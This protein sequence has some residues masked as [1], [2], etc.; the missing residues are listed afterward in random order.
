MICLYNHH[1]TKSALIY[2]ALGI[3]FAVFSSKIKSISADYE[4]VCFSDECSIEIEIEEDMEGPVY[5][6]Y[7]LD[8]F[9][10]NHFDYITSLS[11]EQL[12]GN[13]QTE[14]ELES[15]KP[16]VTAGDLDYSVYNLNGEEMEL[17]DVLYPCGLVATTFFNGTEFF[18]VS[19]FWEKERSF[20]LR[21][22]IDTFRM[23]DSNDNNITISEEGIAWETDI[24]TF[25]NT[26]SDYKSK[27]WI[28]IENNGTKLSSLNFNHRKTIEG[29]QST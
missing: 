6:Y 21:R 14:D 17:S 1:L 13:E 23:M 10:Q 2:I 16:I 18:E 3:I 24:E 29:Q 15:C 12:K 9:F 7:S 19:Y 27:Q 4:S 8:N 22:R 28:E 11:M 20:D 5:L 26:G 25:K